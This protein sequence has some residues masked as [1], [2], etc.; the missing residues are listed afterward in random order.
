MLIMEII[1]M[2]LEHKIIKVEMEQMA[3]GMVTAMV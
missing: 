1:K 3:K 2:V